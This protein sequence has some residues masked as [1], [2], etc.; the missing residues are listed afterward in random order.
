MTAGLL[1]NTLSEQPTNRPPKVDNVVTDRLARLAPLHQTAALERARRDAGAKKPLPTLDDLRIAERPPAEIWR[2]DSVTYPTSP[3]PAAITA[4]T[5]RVMADLAWRA[6]LPVMSRRDREGRA[7][8][9]AEARL[10]PDMNQ[11]PVSRST[12]LNAA[13]VASG[14]ALA[15]LHAPL[16]SALETVLDRL[17]DAVP[18]GALA[19]KTD[20][21]LCEIATQRA[22]AAY[23]AYIM[24]AGVATALGRE[25]EELTPDLRRAHC[26]L[27]Q[28]RQ[29]RQQSGEARQHLAA[30]LGTVGRGAKPYADDYSLARWSEQQGAQRAWAAV[31]VLAGPDGASVPMAEVVA[32]GQAAQLARMYAMVL[33]VDEIAQRRGLAAVFITVTLPPEWHPNPKEGKGERTLTADRTPKKADEALRERWARFRALLADRHV[34]TLG[35]RVWEPHQDGCPH[36]HALLYVR[37]D[38]IETVD[39]ALI[40]VCPEPRGGERIAS[41][42]E[43]IDRTRA[44]PATYVMKYILKAVAQ[45]P[46]DADRLPGAGEDDQLLHYERHRAVASERGWRRYGWLGVHGVQRVWQ[47]LLTTKELPADAPGSVQA[48]WAALHA[49]RWADALE[50]LGAVGPRAEGVRLAYEETETRYGDT[51]RRPVAV[52]DLASGWTMPL[53]RQGWTV[54]KVLT[55]AETE[56]RRLTVVMSCPRSEES[57]GADEWDDNEFCCTLST[58]RVFLAW[59]GPP[60]PA[61]S[62]P[63]LTAA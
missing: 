48:A 3:T 28:R 38:Q 50:A 12:L 10:T 20:P 58:K 55:K 42:F 33:G 53:A 35:L 19:A 59:T 23:Q 32:S 9:V 14:R 27:W 40:G 61:G 34:R 49:G 8:R 24:R 51:A 37:P 2:L 62:P 63:R 22:T 30:A 6:S 43:I 26:P 54:E 18:Q 17:D 44:T 5:R 52:V 57:E 39:D 41:T 21:E 4:E 31:R 36:M 1:G 45:A 15:A 25:Q 29:V 46:G 60:D 7:R 11:P 16:L 13:E 47:R 56:N